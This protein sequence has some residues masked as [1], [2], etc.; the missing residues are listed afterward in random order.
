MK[1][2]K[3]NGVIDSWQGYR[4]RSFLEE[5][6][7]KEVMVR[8]NSY[9]GSIAVAVDMS[10]AMQEHGNV[11]VVHTSLN[12]SAATWLTFGAKRIEMYSDCLLFVHPSSQ[13]KYLWRQ[14]DAEGMKR[15]G[16][17][18]A[19]DADALDKLDQ[20]IAA[21]YASRSS[22]KLDAAGWL[23]K[24]KTTQ[25]LTAD[26]CLELGLVD[27]ILK[28]KKAEKINSMREQDFANCSIPLPEGYEV[29]KT[30][31]QQIVDGVRAFFKPSDEAQVEKENIVDNNTNIKIMKKDW[32]NVNTLLEVEG[33]NVQDNKVVLTLE[34]M[35][36]IENAL[37]AGA[38]NL[39]TAKREKQNA[40]NS[41]NAVVGV[42]DS[43]SD[44]V[45]SK[46]SA[47]EK[48]NLVKEKFD[49]ITA[50]AVV[51]NNSGKGKTEKDTDDF[52][53]CRID[54]VNFI[55]EE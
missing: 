44:E 35:E 41:L 47:V 34:Q 30:L 42:L 46:N 31:V 22:G 20:M 50:G 38:E 13:E 8:L 29:E 36:K 16:A 10:H 26:E 49:K 37:K 15:L 43:L 12:A 4:L 33:V 45:K 51:V 5:N 6:K 18:V 53:D 23:Q 2:L 3:I 9:G 40:E 39:T 1:E 14:L 7:G 48:V 52:E 19:A 25:W 54:P 21:K 27:E 24:M 32:V 11:T 17:E 55:F 28:D